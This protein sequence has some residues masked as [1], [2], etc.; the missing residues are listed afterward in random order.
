MSTRRPSH[1]IARKTLASILLALS[2]AVVA[3]N[4]GAP[5]PETHE[6]MTQS[7]ALVGNGKLEA[8]EQ[9][10]DGNTVSGDGCSASGV[11]EAGY[12]CHVPGR[13]CS[14]ASLCGNGVVNSGEACDDGNTVADANGC[15]SSCGLALCG[16]GLLN[17]RQ[18]PNFDQEIC[19][20]GN[21]VEGDGCSRLCEVEPGFACSGTPS[22]CV[23]TGVLLFNTGV[24]ANNRRLASGPDSHWFYSGTSTGAATGVRDGADWPNEVQTAQFMA[25]PLGAP[26]CVY[27]DFLVPS[28]LDVARF[29]LRL[30]TF[31]DN[32]F[33]G[34]LVNGVA[35]TPITVAE[36]PGQ[37]WQKNVVREFGSSAPWRSGLNRITLCNENEASAPNAFRYLVVDAYDDRCGDGVLS[38]RE[39][40]DDG[41]VTANDG[42]SA[43]CG[44]ERGY[45]CIGSP[46]ACAATCGNGALNAS[47]ECDDGNI[48]DGDGCS[49]SCRVEAGRACPVPGAACVATCGNG[50]IDAG[51][52][53]DDGNSMG[54]DGCSASCRMERGYACSG[55]PSTCA[56]TCGNGRLD[57]GELCDD[58]NTSYGD[59]CS[60]AC[61]L[62][63]GYACAT[64]GQPCARTCGNGTINP[65]EQC[66]DGNLVSG[67]GCS[68]ECRPERGYAC[69]APASGPSHCLATCG[70]GALNANETCDDGNTSSGDGCSDGC[71]VE[72]GYSCSGSP[73]N[74]SPLC[75]DGIRAANEQCD[76]G[77][78]SSGD[79]CSASCRVESGWRCPA[80][81]NVCFHTCG[82]GT[83][84][85]GESCDD[86]NTIS[87]DGCDAIC[88][89]EAGF[90][91]SGRPSSCSALCG[92]G[93]R[94][95]GELCDDRNF[96]A[97]DGCDAACR[98]EPGFGCVGN[99]SVCAVTCG[100][101]I[102]S[103]TEE[104]DDGNVTAGDGCDAS[105]RVE[106]GFG[107]GNTGVGAVFTRRGR[108]SCTQVANMTE[109]TLPELAIQPA[110]TVPGRYRLR[111]VSGAVSY[112]GGASWYP[113]V[114]GVNYSSA[115]EPRRFA[116][117]FIGAGSATAVEAEA[118]GASQ[119][120]DFDA[121]AGDVRVALVDTDCA[122]N[123]NSDTPV[124]YRADALSICQRIPLLTNPPAPA[125]LTSGNVGGDAS[126][127]ATVRVYLDAA[128]D[129]ACTATADNGGHWTCNL[130]GATP[131]AHAAV[132]AATVLSA[133]EA[134]AAVTITIDPTAPAA[135]VI[136][137]P[138]S[139]AHLSASP[140]AISGTA[141]PESEVTVREGPTELCAATTDAAGQWSCVPT[142]SLPDGPHSVTA[143]AVDA[144]GNSG[145][146]SAVTFTLDTR[147]PD[148][149]FK[150]QP[151]ART[152][153]RNASFAYASTEASVR[154]ECSLDGAPFHP[155]S[156][157]YAVALGDHL[158]RAR[159][160]DLAGNVDPSPA[161]ARWTVEEAQA[162]PEPG[163]PDAP[164]GGADTGGG[165]GGGGGCS[166]APRST[167]N[168]PGWWIVLG[169]S[170]LR[171]L[172]RRR[173]SSAE[174]TVD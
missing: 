121:V 64:A 61:T 15:S 144:A 79:G 27:Q 82:N 39:D 65:G 150:E 167:S 80:P 151:P 29:R 104:C 13:A 101:G 166:A 71:R 5:A 162:T 74:C 59:G 139:G 96:T 105:C 154:F 84:E 98:I 68:S 164:Q 107:C 124:A 81:G 170:C 3:C 94:T 100:D 125:R 126:P 31:N 63:L 92:D 173:A 145:P 83:V 138:T 163:P 112:S 122:L 32:A 73:S 110:I 109:P 69:S 70:N 22:R 156:D 12:L 42:C 93:I 17:N 56:L 40:C 76:D 2:T 33:D 141:E 88:R 1:A 137:A 58:G 48:I 165:G 114:I 10:D 91:C 130:A 34:A 9:C 172:A 135:P 25:A 14:L 62:E 30:A 127:G 89:V 123:D 7:S 55:A 149:S 153:E 158:L 77:N 41:N 152:S 102:L 6:V 146:S 26:V 78:T 21:L 157:A 54:G 108:T 44:I 35:F 4:R 86:G 117:G 8:G 51:E 142:T 111:H 132:V 19:D 115:A 57:P 24:D 53:C 18:W 85:E 169:L 148:T 136:L 106:A 116:L 120:R 20:D 103:A 52:L 113:G 23:R 161:E 128:I 11:L 118:V 28:T 160:V 43:T 50:V 129:P 155:C 168:G 171:L 133:T 140:A 99:P 159:A 60:N 143:T 90:G 67:D 147:A 72:V 131:G 134:A 95:G 38:P 97:G 49:S 46:S 119:Q 75:G 66:D 87:G 45:A 47:E 37:P 36:P 16:N 174:A